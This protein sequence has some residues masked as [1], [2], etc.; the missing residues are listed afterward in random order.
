MERNKDYVN[1]YDALYK[2]SSSNED[3]IDKI[4]QDIKINLIETNV[5]PPSQMLANI[6]DI[7]KFNNRYFKSYWLIFKKIFEEYHLTEIKSNSTIFNYFVYKEYGI[8]LDD[9]NKSD[10]EFGRYEDEN[11]SL[12]VHEENTVYRA[13]MNDDKQSLIIYAERPGFDKD[14]S[15][16]SEFYP[17][18][19]PNSLLELCC[20]HGAVNCFKLLRSKFNSEITKKCLWNSFLGGNQ[21]I[22]SECLKIQ[23]PDYECMR[24]AIISHNVDFITFLMNEY[25]IAIDLYHCGYYNN[26]QAFL[27]YL[28]QTLDMHKCLVYS[29]LFN[30]PS[31]VEYLI[32]HDAEINTKDKYGFAALHYATI[33]NSKEIINILIDHHANI[34]AKDINGGTALHIATRNNNKDIAELLISNGIDINAKTNNGKTALKIAIENNYKEIEDLLIS[35]STK[36]TK[37]S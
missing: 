14:Q 34:N 31:L 18:N 15:L 13:I 27:I 9:E 37:R 23:S 3:Q 22:M 20:Y 1:A 8:V 35:H 29:P 36:V 24:Y 21:E 5:F 12:E 32:A 11:Y 33:K 4:Y 7:S 30:I 28:D 19:A 25:E 26:L 10:S 6:I 16:K 2:L 17:F